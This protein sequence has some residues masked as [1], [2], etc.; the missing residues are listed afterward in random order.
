MPNAPEFAKSYSITNRSEPFTY[1]TSV[2]AWVTP[3]PKGR[4][5]F[6]EA[7][8]KYKTDAGQ[9]ESRDQKSFL[10]DL[11]SDL[12]RTAGQDAPANLVVF[13]HGLGY[14]YSDAILDTANLGLLL[15]AGFR[16]I[17][18]WS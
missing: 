14:A 11:R 17:A 10:D 12:E 5:S 18:G 1:M 7:D 4:L 9:Y 3:L 6:Y 16:G 15:Q 8:G 2:A 13:I